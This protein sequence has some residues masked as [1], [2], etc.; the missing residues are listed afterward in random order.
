VVRPR[1]VALRATGRHKVGRLPGSGDMRRNGRPLVRAAVA[2][3]AYNLDLG[4]RPTLCRP[5]AR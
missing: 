3:G 5:A 2:V 1:S 4:S